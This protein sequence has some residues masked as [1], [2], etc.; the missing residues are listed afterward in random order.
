MS[1]AKTIAPLP[2][3][4]T[5]ISP[6][7]SQ[8]G[9]LSVPSTQCSLKRDDESVCLATTKETEWLDHM[10]ENVEEQMEICHPPE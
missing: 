4:Y 7:S 6:L 5:N 3:S 8:K 9:A 2:S 1:K 10:R